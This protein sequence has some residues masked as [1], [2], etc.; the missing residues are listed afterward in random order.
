MVSGWR[1]DVRDP[2]LFVVGP[3]D[4]FTSLKFVL[5][6]RR[7]GAWTLTLPADHPQAG[8]LVEGAG[9]LVWAPWSTDR[10]VMSGP[11]TKLSAAT[12]TRDKGSELTV[13]GVDDTA[14]LG[15]RLVLP[16]PGSPMSQQDA[17]AYWTLTAKAEILLRILID[18][19]AGNGALAGR[20]ILDADPL[21]RMFDPG[22]MYGTARSVTARF[23]NL[24]ALAG[25]VAA[26]DNLALEV[27][28]PG[29]G[30]Q[31]RHLH[32]WQPVDRSDY[33]RLSQYAGTLTSAVANIAAPTAT[34]V[35]VA[36]GGEGVARVLVERSADGLTQS[37]S[38]RIEAFRDA[39]D[40]SDP[41][42][43]AERG[44]ETL[45][46]AAVSAGISLVPVDT[47]AQRYGYDY[48]LG[49]TV[50]VDVAGGSYTEVVSGVEIT[51][52]AGDAVAVVPQVGDPDLADMRSPLIYRRMA[53]LLRRIEQLERRQ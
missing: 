38:R 11:V 29:G 10:P 37:W 7:A 46:D 26:T 3:C 9:I 19:N 34:H 24:L 48:G 5:R 30:V 20:R 31:D 53:D 51:V 6:H 2:D 8:L 17:D 41:A 28:Q 14:L 25:E 47:P 44:D 36:G 21:G 50:T 45:A 40:T 23:D 43:L 13:E 4:V 1:I 52:T 22:S 16:N 49:D 12:A 39:R 15:D 18:V 32:V 33:V 27:V 35:L 42:I